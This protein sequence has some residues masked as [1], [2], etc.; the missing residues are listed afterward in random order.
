MTIELLRK[1]CYIFL[2]ISISILSAF[3]K[4]LKKADII[5]QIRAAACEKRVAHIDKNTARRY[6]FFIQEVTS[7]HTS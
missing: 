7:N 6:D 5:D 4:S 2:H 1:E 3:R